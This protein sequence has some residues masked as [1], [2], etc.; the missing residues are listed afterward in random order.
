MNNET[1]TLTLTPTQ[2]DNLYTALS[3]AIGGRL[4]NGVAVYAPDAEVFQALQDA[5]KGQW[6]AQDK[7]F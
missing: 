3:C 1:I 5:I 6:F 4:G 2:V 7:R